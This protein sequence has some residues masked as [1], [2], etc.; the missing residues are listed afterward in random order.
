MNESTQKMSF[1][2]PF[3]HCTKQ[4]GDKIATKAKAEAKK[5]KENKN[6]KRK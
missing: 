4:K 2:L 5:K 3:E 6:V 1:F